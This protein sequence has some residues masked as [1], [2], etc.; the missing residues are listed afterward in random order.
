MENVFSSLSS[1]FKYVLWSPPGNVDNGCKRSA[2]KLLVNNFNANFFKFIT[3]TVCWLRTDEDNS[4]LN[5]SFYL[6][7]LKNL[8]INVEFRQKANFICVLAIEI[9]CSGA[10]SGQDPTFVLAFAKEMLKKYPETT[11]LALILI[12]ESLPFCTVSFIV[13]F[14]RVCEYKAILVI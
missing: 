4:I 1:F 14:L 13:H 8:D 9:A 3:K 2:W 10:R 5:A 12:A 7:D 6:T 11:D